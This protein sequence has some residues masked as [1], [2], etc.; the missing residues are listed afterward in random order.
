MDCQAMLFWIVKP[1][2]MD[3]QA[4]LFSIELYGGLW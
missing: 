3:C 2:F 4:M 1:C